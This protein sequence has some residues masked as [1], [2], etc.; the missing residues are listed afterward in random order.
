MRKK[1][2]GI[3]VCTLLI[4]TALPAIGM[5]INIRDSNAVSLVGTDGNDGMSPSP[6]FWWL[7][8]SDQKQLKD[9]YGFWI[10]PQWIW[11]Q[12]FKPS[13]DKLTAVSLW[14]FKGGNPPDGIE[15]TVIIRNSLNGE[16]L[17]EKKI[18]AD[19]IKMEPQAT[20]VLF[21]FEDITVTPEETYYILCTGSGGDIYNASYW[22]LD[23]NTSYN[24]GI[25]WSSYDSGNTWN[26]GRN[27]DFCFITYWKKPRNRAINTP[28]LNF[29]QQHPNL[30]PILRHLLRL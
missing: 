8:G 15:I 10:I 16:N 13:K 30:F 21:D 1:I 19:K 20:W 6:P 11:V 4:A 23:Y 26:K 17:A 28:F 12:E 9:G 22:M 25:T 18:N 5:N 14:F 7:I 24:R 2:I 3:L 29:L 27:I